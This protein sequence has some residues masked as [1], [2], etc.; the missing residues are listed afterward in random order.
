MARQHRSHTSKRVELSTR[1]AS[2]NLTLSEHVSLLS[3]KKDRVEQLQNQAKSL[4]SGQVNINHSARIT[5]PSAA[6]VPIKPHRFHGGGKMA[7]YI[8]QRRNRYAAVSFQK[9]FIDKQYSIFKTRIVNE[10]LI[11]KGVIK[12]DGCEEHEVHLKFIPGMPPKVTLPKLKETSK[13]DVHMYNDGSLCLF[14]PGNQK[15]TDYTKIAE[16]TIPW[17]V[18][19]IYL[20]E[21]W[22]LT[23]KWEADE[24]PVH[25]L[26]NRNC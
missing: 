14:Y 7:G 26:S 10:T 17:V 15:W 13:F 11:C 20:Y 22:K 4:Q 3:A 23:G 12:I 2:T 1:N 5:V 6:S 9:Y 21:I 16:Y 25:N 18:E 24:S 19:W 8:P